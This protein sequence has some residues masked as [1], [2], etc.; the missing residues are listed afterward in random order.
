MDGLVQVLACPEVYTLYNTCVHVYTCRMYVL[1]CRVESLITDT[2]QCSDRSGN[3]FSPPKQD[4]LS[5]Y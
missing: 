1:K 4:N 5:N 3:K 2:F